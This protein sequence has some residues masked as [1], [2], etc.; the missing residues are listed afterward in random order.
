MTHWTASAVQ[1][2]GILTDIVNRS[3]NNAVLV[4]GGFESAAFPLPGGVTAGT[5][6]ANDWTGIVINGVAS[7]RDQM[8]KIPLGACTG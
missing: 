3:G 1:D 5:P 7:D 6:L 2:G 4:M 8:A